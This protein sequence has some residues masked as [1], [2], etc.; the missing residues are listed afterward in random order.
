MLYMCHIQNIY[1]FVKRG[2]G[3][4]KTAPIFAMTCYVFIAK[5]AELQYQT[6]LMVKSATVRGEVE[7]CE[8]FEMANTHCI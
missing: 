1:I 8:E 4:Y 2:L 3:E 5:R 7:G 6:K